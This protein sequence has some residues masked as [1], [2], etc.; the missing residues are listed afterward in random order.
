MIADPHK[1]KEALYA[2]YLALAGRYHPDVVKEPKD[3]AEAHFRKIEEAHEILRDALQSWAYDNV[4]P[5]QHVHALKVSAPH[6]NKA[7]FGDSE[8]GGKIERFI[9]IFLVAAVLLFC[10]W[11]VDIPSRLL[12]SPLRPSN[13]NHQ[14]DVAQAEISPQSNPP[15]RPTDQN[16][17]SDP[18]LLRSDPSQQS[19]PASQPSDQKHEA[20]LDSPRGRPWLA[21]GEPISRPAPPHGDYRGYSNFP[22]WRSHDPQP[23]RPLR[24]CWRDRGMR[25]PCF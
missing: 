25:G 18:T 13:Q 22:A 4:P 1:H 17:Q 24:D 15:L 21:D 16:H 12:P 8:Q 23:R 19:S 10:C 3:A 6:P 5:N 2:A 11:M 9:K 20:V 7:A 14:S